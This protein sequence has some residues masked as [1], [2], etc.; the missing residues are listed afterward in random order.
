MSNTIFWVPS[1]QEF[2]PARFTSSW[3]MR[4]HDSILLILGHL[5]L[6]CKPKRS[7]FRP[8]RRWIHWSHLCPVEKVAHSWVKLARASWD[9]SH[10]VETSGRGTD[11][12]QILNLINL[13][14]MPSD[15]FFSSPITGHNRVR[16]FKEL[17][18]FL[19]PL[20]AVSQEAE[21]GDF[22]NFIWSVSAAPHRQNIC[23]RPRLYSMWSCIWVAVVVSLCSLQPRGIETELL[24]SS[25]EQRWRSPTPLFQWHVGPW[26]C[27]NG[28]DVKHGEL[29]DCP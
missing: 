27:K 17:L 21:C 6:S 23:L 3:W 19:Y 26:L 14:M 18:A 7:T 11:S 4:R 28:Q 10:G 5:H 15:T 8:S 16:W 1:V 13:S 2:L 9:H 29:C 24:K 22:A 12:Q 20:P 25:T